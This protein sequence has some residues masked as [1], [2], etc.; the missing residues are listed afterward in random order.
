M[1]K[2]CNYNKPFYR[3]YHETRIDH[4]YTTNFNELGSGAHGWK[5]EGIAGYIAQQ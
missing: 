1:Q 5:F 3:Y 4:F 2:Q